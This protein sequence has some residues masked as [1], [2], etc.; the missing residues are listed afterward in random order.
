M[1]PTRWPPP[2]SEWVAAG[3]AVPRP[4]GN[5]YWLLPGRVLAGEHPAAAGAHALPLRLQG[6]QAAGVTCCIDLTGEVD[7]LRAYQPLAVSGRAARR[8]G[9]AIADFGI[10]T[11]AGMRRVLDAID[12]ACVG[13]EVVFLHCR[14][15][16]GRTGTV[17]GCLLVEHG[18]SGEEALALV[19]RKFSAMSKSALVR[20]SPETGEQRA[21]VQRWQEG[22][23][24]P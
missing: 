8:A 1:P 16:I 10:P 5:T 24:R 6:L 17:A 7:P 15:G 9:F 21:F 2:R 3:D 23:G 22:A 19:Q 13:G 20:Q 12:V 14:A 4:H 18:F 11:T